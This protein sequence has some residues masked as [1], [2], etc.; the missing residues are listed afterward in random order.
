MKQIDDFQILNFVA[1]G[2]SDQLAIWNYEKSMLTY[3]IIQLYH[4]RC[5]ADS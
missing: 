2:E 4:P 1:F 5:L 3:Q